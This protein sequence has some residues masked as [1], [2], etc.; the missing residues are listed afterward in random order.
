MIYNFLSIYKV[1]LNLDEN[2]RTNIMIFHNFIV[3]RH[4]LQDIPFYGWCFIVYA[5]YG[6]KQS[7]S[8]VSSSSFSLLTMGL[9][10][11]CLPRP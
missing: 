1:R 6:V 2:Q 8:N 11:L 3:T 9:E 10:T 5:Y 4:K 7:L